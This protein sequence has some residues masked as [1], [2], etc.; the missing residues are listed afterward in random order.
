MLVEEKIVDEK[1]RLDFK[2][3]IHSGPSPVKNYGIA[4][5]RALRFPSSLI[6]RAD[7]LIDKI[8]D[9]SVLKYLNDVSDDKKKL[10]QNN[11]NGDGEDV[12]MQDESKK[13]INTTEE[14][15]ELEKDVID[16]YSYVL[17]LMST[18][19]DKKFDHIS[20]E[21]INEKLRE[22]IQTMSPEFRDL[23]KQSSLDEIIGILNCSKSSSSNK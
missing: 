13:T 6:D 15:N 1:M 9:E 21:I 23:L 14:I 12:T 11:E 5:A 8:E 18:E 19:K 20:I 17:L 4:L 7:D 3:K 2:Y 10:V 16:L 22:L